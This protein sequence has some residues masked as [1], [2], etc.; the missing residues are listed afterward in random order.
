[1]P[2]STAAPRTSPQG[3]KRSTATTSSRFTTDVAT[4]FA[5]EAMALVDHF[6]FLD[7]MKSKAPKGTKPKPIASKPQG[8]LEVGWFLSTT[9]KWTAPYYDPNDLRSVDRQLF[10]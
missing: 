2:S 1:M 9:D 3:A 5:I 6:D 7:R 4:V 10:A 8:A